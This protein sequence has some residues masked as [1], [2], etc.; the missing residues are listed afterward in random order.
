MPIFVEQPLNFLNAIICECQYAVV[1]EAIDPDH[2]VLG[3][4]CKGD[5][6]DKVFIDAEILGEA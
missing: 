5:V 6:V 3:F 2:A 4:K 1:V